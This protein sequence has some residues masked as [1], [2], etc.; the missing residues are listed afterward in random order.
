MKD[1]ALADGRD[2]QDRLEFWNDYKIVYE[3]L[4]ALPDKERTWQGV[5]QLNRIHEVFSC[6]INA[7]D[8]GII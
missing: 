2:E 8:G 3:R 4:S 5:L 1:R 6:G 7:T